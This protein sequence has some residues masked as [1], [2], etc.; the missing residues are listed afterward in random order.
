M[1]VRA[2][3]ERHDGTIAVESREGAGSA[4]TVRLPL[5]PAAPAGG[6][7]ERPPPRPIAGGTL[8]PVWVRARLRR[9]A[10]AAVRAR[11]AGHG[12]AVARASV[13]LVELRAGTRALCTPER[14][15]AARRT[16][17]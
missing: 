5:E 2:V 7:P 1:V 6:R 16:G 11:I 9:E 12:D 17:S 3:V 14:E 4:L 13:R 8:S 15:R 10:G